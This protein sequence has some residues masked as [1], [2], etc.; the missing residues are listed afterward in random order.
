MNKY[1]R[2]LSKGHN[3][4]VVAL[5]NTE[6]GKIFTPDS[7]VEISIE[8][9][10][11]K[12]ANSI[13]GLVCKFIRIDIDE[14]NQIL[15]ME[16]LEVLDYRTFEIEIREAMFM[17]LEKKLTELHSNGFVHRDI[18]RPSGFNGEPYDNIILT[19]NGFR[20]I[21]VGISAIK[22]RTGEALFQ[23]YVRAELE[24]LKD[25]SDYMLNR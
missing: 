11:M 9:E 6:A 1:P 7:R 14:P 2:Q 20:L 3:N 18:Q 16:R 4:A 21:D 24:E 10:N 15:V 8:A 17:E 12:Y 25:F 5:S 19:N 13:N 23:S 22:S